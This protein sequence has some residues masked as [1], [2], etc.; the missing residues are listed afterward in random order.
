[1]FYTLSQ[2]KVEKP[3]FVRQTLSTGQKQKL[4]GFKQAG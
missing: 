2:N 3:R 4:E 1:V